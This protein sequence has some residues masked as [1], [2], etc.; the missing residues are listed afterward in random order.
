ME[1]AVG[2]GHAAAF[3]FGQPA[4]GQFFDGVIDAGKLVAAVRPDFRPACHERKRSADV[5][6]E[7]GGDDDVLRLDDIEAMGKR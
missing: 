5:A 1:R 6:A 2:D 3:R 4:A 7:F